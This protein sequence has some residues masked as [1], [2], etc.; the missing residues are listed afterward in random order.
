[1]ALDAATLYVTAN[2]LKRELIGARVDKLYMPTRDEVV[3]GLRTPAG[4]KKLLISARSGS[5]RVH[6]TAEE[7]ENPAVPPS[8]CM[9][10]RKYLASGRITGLR[11]VDGER[12]LFIDFDTL[13]EM[14]DRTQ[15]TMSVELM[16]RYCNLVL[17]NA[18]G[19]VIDALKRIDAD[20]SD[21]RQLLP[22]LPFTMPPMQDKLR[23]LSSDP[24]EIARRA[25]GMPRPLSA[26]VLAAVVGIGPA[27]C[28]EIAYRVDPADPDADRLGEDARA[29]LA[30]QIERVQRAAC[31]EGQRLCA[32]YDG[33]RPVEFS[34]IE[35][36]QYAGCALRPFESMSA[37]LDSYYAEKDRVE[38]MKARS[39]DL[40]RQVHNLVE[41]A[42]RKQQARLSEQRN[43]EKAEQK[44]LYGE[45]IQANLHAL[46]RGMKQAELLNYY[47]GEPVTVPLDVTKSP[48]QNA[49]KYFKDYRKLMTAA[50]MLE[51]LLA[52]G[53]A[54]IDY[55]RS[56]AYEIT[57]ARTE[58]DFLLIRKELK[59]AGY[60][61]GF[62]YKEQKKP[63]KLADCLAYRTSEGFRVLVGRNNAANDRLTLK[64]AS[65]RDLWFHVKNAAGSHTVLIAQGEPPTDK[66]K[67]EAACIA[68]WHSS[69][70]GGEN[71]PV[72]Y[73]EIK[74][75]K[76]APGQ[77]TGMV[78]YVNYQTA[79]V[80]PDGQAVEA[81]REKEK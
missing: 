42:E 64:T 68:A 50:K 8:F 79:F 48:V 67:T 38:R 53:A 34:F 11:T 72:D 26:A 62:K 4:A 51:K 41:R 6:L 24:A 31:G 29:A 70:S 55:L 10:L 3:L 76:K 20:A 13:N 49:Q 7:F 80:T 32:V 40:S 36:R 75:V 81:M 37:L 23:F 54:E 45:L 69:L 52:E 19:R 59:E 60:L 2:E 21:V 66:A 22:G 44:R 57:L 33:S 58:E 77:K 46:Q 63:R 71:I 30:A 5:A 74:N 16:G 12:I 56:V 14:G 39:Y 28:R 65:K 43:T 35:L 17:V 73:T 27:L 9:L 1:M 18:E 47:T 15:L 61:R 25:C 78:I